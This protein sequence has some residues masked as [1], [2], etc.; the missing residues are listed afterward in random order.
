MPTL[1]DVARHAG[2]STA[3]VSK[4]LSNTPYFTE[5][6]RS[7]VM[8]AVR[9]LGYRPNLAA[10]ALSSGKTHTIA[11]VFPHVYDTIFQDPLVMQILEGVERVCSEQQYNLLLS[12]PH[13]S[14]DGPDENYHQL[15]QSG[16]IEGVI[17]ID[18]VQIASVAL[19]AIELGIP[20][21]VIGYHPATVTVRC[22][23][24]QGGV[25]TM[26][27]IIGLGHRQ[28]GIITVDSHLNFAIEARIKG[29]R[30]AA[31]QHG[32][33][34]DRLP[35]IE[36]DFSVS[37]GAR[38]ARKLIEKY[39]ELTAVI[40]LNDRMAIGAIQQM[41]QMGRSIPDD[42]SV[43]GYDN[44]KMSGVLSPSLTTINQQA[45]SQG[46]IAARMLF[47]ILSDK[48]PEAVVLAPDLIQRQSSAAPRSV[49]VRR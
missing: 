39:P 5:E 34:F 43:I 32:V 13:L 16:Y 18:N 20:T 48:Q 47:E 22:D 2:V 37:G 24:Y 49:S 4:V 33:D 10:R 42:L 36:S 27:H 14:A 19:A 38:A 21:V 15:I 28:I 1:Q 25:L 46:E 44:I 41:H 8:T 17:A 45:P 9:A 23:D 12:T 6:T 35:Q 30:A 11:V 31:S 29:M 26:A 40:C 3:T 7:K